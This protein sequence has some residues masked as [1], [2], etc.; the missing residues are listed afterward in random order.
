MTRAIKNIKQAVVVDIE[1]SVKAS[2]EVG[3]ELGLS[4]ERELAMNVGPFQVHQWGFSWACRR[5]SEKGIVIGAK[6]DMLT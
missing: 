4:S 5:T 6:R 1:W 3:S 2:G